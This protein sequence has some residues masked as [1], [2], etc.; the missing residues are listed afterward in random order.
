[1]LCL[2]I[3]RIATLAT[4]SFL[5]LVGCHGEN[6][7]NL[8]TDEA[9]DTGVDTS[10]SMGSDAG[11]DA[12]PDSAD[13]ADGSDAQCPPTQPDAGS[14]EGNFYCTY[15]VDGVLLP[16]R[17][18]CAYRDV[19]CYQGQLSIT[20]NDPGTT[21]CGTFSLDG[22]YVDECT[23]AGGTCIDPH[24]H[25]CAAGSAS[26]WSLSCGPSPT[27]YCCLSSTKADGASCMDSSQCKSRVCWGHHDF[28]NPGPPGVCIE[29]C[30]TMTACNAGTTCAD[31]TGCVSLDGGPEVC[32]LCLPTCS[33]A[34]ACGVGTC[35]PRA[36]L[37][38]TTETVCDPCAPA[39]DA[40]DA[41]PGTC[42]TP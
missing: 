21:Q 34:G 1:M 41:A 28:S 2:S 42:T 39:S 6:T 26:A 25:N 10:V 35:Q 4:L 19:S 40:G 32:G 30:N 38:G 14:C 29:T 20:H 16:E 18:P 7:D 13:A 23:P 31:L 9:T 36:T 5:V 8:P 11:S 33:D 24:I 15:G 12:T 3:M 17:P 27:T 22:S 37:A